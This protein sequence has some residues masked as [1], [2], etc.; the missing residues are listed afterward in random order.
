LL[1]NSSK[2]R[3]LKNI[4]SLSDALAYIKVF[5]GGGGT[6][7]RQWIVTG[8]VVCFSANSFVLDQ[9]SGRKLIVF[10]IAAIKNVEDV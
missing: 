1:G 4:G 7:T 5:A 10:A 6:S 8:R 2:K 3:L 9:T